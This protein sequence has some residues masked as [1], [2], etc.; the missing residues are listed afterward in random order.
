M[1]IEYQIIYWRD[2]PAQVKVRAEAR[3]LARG[4]SD[5]FQ[6]A[7]DEAAMQVGLAGTDDYLAE[8]RVSPWQQRD[9]E[10]ETIADGLVSE[11]E[12]QYPPSRLT[13]VVLNGGRDSEANQRP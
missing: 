9:G 1:T 2:I 11:V 13:K 7:I 5:R 10:P 8:W 12:A 6:E 3:R 4:L